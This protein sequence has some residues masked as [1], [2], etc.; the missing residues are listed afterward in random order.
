MLRYITVT[1]YHVRLEKDIGKILI[2]QR[3]VSRATG[4]ENK[5]GCSHGDIR[6]GKENKRFETLIR[7]NRIH[8]NY[9]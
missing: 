8:R 5:M 6:K 1:T 9:S 7:A 2:S 3:Y 4:T